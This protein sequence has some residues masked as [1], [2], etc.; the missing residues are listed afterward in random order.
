MR[1][2]SRSIDESKDIDRAEDTV[3]AI[4]K[5]LQGLQ[6]EFDAEIAALEQKIDPLTEELETTTIKPS[7]SDIII[8]LVALAWTP[9][10][11]DEQGNLTEAW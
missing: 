8:Q 6:A 2:V 1:G 3:E 10:W 7:K 5:Q 4:Q 9:F 11:Q